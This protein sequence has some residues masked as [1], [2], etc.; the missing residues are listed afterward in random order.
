MG[1]NSSVKDFT[2]LGHDVFVGMGASVTNDTKSGSV[3]INN[4]SQTFDE[5]D[6]RA[7]ILKKGFFK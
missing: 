1:V 6:K 4:S 2:T 5:N 3:V 7:K